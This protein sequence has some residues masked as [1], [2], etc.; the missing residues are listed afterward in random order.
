MT[1][2]H[3]LDAKGLARGHRSGWATGRVWA[4][5]V[6][7]R[8]F[9]SMACG[10]QDRSF[11]RLAAKRNPEGLPKPETRVSSLDATSWEIRST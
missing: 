9:P 11:V 4:G 5:A 3:K 8:V 1:R 7:I 10:L 2:I 6:R